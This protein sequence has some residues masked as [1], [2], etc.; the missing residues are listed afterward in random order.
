[1]ITKLKYLVIGLSLITYAHGITFDREFVPATVGAIS[2]SVSTFT[3]LQLRCR[4]APLA[5]KAF[6]VTSMLPL[7]W[8]AG[9]MTLKALHRK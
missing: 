8:G 3:F 6:V 9:L 1:M 5:M 2:G 7:G 4:Q